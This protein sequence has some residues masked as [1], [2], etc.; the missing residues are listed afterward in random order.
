MRAWGFTYKTNLVAQPDR[1]GVVPV[2]VDH[3]PTGRIGSRVGQRG[4]GFGAEHPGGAGD[5]LPAALRPRGLAPLTERR[6]GTVGPVSADVGQPRREPA[7]GRGELEPVVPE[8]STL[9]RLA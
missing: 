2:A 9:D 5:T 4:T 7:E 3:R 1:R 8:P 6:S